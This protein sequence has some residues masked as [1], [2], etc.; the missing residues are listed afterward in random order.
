VRL[1]LTTTLPITRH[2]RVRSEANPYDPADEVYFEERL[3]VSMRH[4][5]TG[6]TLLLRLW[7]EQNGLCPFCQQKITKTTGWHAHHIVWRSKGGSDKGANRVLL[8]PDCHRRVHRQGLTVVKPRPF[9]G[10][11]EA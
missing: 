10:V 6:K 9:R 11:G 7:E 2:V 5:L 8:H 1:F 3:G 4:T